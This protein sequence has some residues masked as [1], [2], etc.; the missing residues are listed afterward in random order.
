[1]DLP[2]II[3]GPAVLQHNG[4]SFYSKD[5]FRLGYKRDTWDATSDIAGP[6]DKRMLRDMFTIS[7]TPDGQIANIAKY[8]PYGPADVGKTIFK[9]APDD[10]VVIWTKGGKKHIWQK[11]AVTKCP[12]L[13]LVPSDTLF[14]DM[15]ITV[16]GKAAT[17]P[18]DAAYFK[19]AVAASAFVDATFDETLIKSGVFSAAWGGA[20][21]ASMGALS[22]FIM[23]I[24]IGVEQINCDLGIADIHLASLVGRARFVPSNLT[25][26][27]FDSLMSFQG[28]SVVLPGQSIA[29][30]GKD[31][32]IASDAFSA[33]LFKAGPIGMTQMFKRGSHIHDAVEFGA[34]RTWTAGAANPLFSFSIL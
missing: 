18:T 34:K 29:K 23:G 10:T 19:Q 30:A 14:G 26:A 33:T 15:E 17:L 3:P 13:R 4:G 9:S 5:G 21:Y 25:E 22:G 16:I 6:I 11:G 28:A 32:V 27:D 24:D 12:E 8:F 2:N 1:M 20:P 7:W 31:L